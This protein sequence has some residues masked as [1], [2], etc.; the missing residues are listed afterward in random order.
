MTMW[1]CLSI[2]AFLLAAL[3]FSDHLARAQLSTAS[4][5]PLQHGHALLIGIA[6]YQ[7]NNWPPLEDIPLQIQALRKGLEPHFD[8]VEFALDLTAAQL[9]VRLETF[10]ATYENE[11]NS[12]LLI[13]YAGH[14]YTETILE[15]N[16]KR[17][18]ITGVD[19]PPI[20]RSRKA[21]DNA[22]P[23][24]VSMGI[25][26]TDLQ[27]SRAHSVLFVFDSCFAGTIFTDRGDNPPVPLP[28]EKIKEL[29]QK[30]LRAKLSRLEPRPK[31]CLLTA[32][33]PN[34][35]LMH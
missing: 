6:H 31:P 34:Y 24:A 13:Y 9:R 30:L 11:T 17:G 3:P 5:D 8:S 35:S 4:D 16:E 15:Y 19:T 26:R 22:R 2:V 28:G 1:R 12:R 23:K 32:L 7:D 29:L 18:F 33:S 14:G 27:E 21:Y 20:D 25:I 10:L